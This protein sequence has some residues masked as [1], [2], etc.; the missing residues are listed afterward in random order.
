MKITKCKQCPHLIKRKM[1]FLENYECFIIGRPVNPETKPPYCEVSDKFDAETNEAVYQIALSR[2]KYLLKDEWFN[3]YN[4]LKTPN[5]LGAYQQG[6]Y[7]G[8]CDILVKLQNNL[9]DITAGLLLPDSTMKT[10][11]NVEVNK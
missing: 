5:D 10:T 3:A 1:S 9:D 4:K 6:W 2:I 11:R 8:Q 7:S